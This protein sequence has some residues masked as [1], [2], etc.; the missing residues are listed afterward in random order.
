LWSR[1]DLPLTENHRLV[2]SGFGDLDDQDVYSD[3]FDPMT[4]DKTAR[5]VEHQSRLSQRPHAGAL[6]QQLGIRIDAT[7]VILKGRLFYPLGASATPP[8]G[9]HPAHERGFWVTAGAFSALEQALWLPLQRQQ[10]LAPVSH[11]EPVHCIET[12]ALVAR[13]RDRPLRH[14]LCIARIVNGTETERGFVVP[15][16]WLQGTGR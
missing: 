12:S 3:A 15:D 4:G 10:W 7:W 16:E 14:P 1:L 8:H 5:L 6:L 13:W 9:A 2:L 11:V